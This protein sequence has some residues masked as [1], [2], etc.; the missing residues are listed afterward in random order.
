MRSKG[1]VVALS[2]GVGVL[3]AV[4]CVFV[5]FAPVFIMDAVRS[6]ED[7]NRTNPL[8]WFLS[9]SLA[10]FCIAGGITV[11]ALCLFVRSRWLAW[12]VAWLLTAVL[13]ICIPAP[14]ILSGDYADDLIGIYLIGI[15][16]VNLGAALAVGLTRRGR[17][18]QG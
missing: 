12:I 13:A 3:A 15:L 11:I 14:A 7:I 6:I 4:A 8:G 5:A 10:G 16:V 9:T 1:A 17:G 18:L 2:L